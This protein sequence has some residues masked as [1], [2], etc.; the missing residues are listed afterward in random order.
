M[1]ALMRLRVEKD[2][3]KPLALDWRHLETTVDGP[4]LVQLHIIGL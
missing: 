4:R 2:I 3:Y 1:E